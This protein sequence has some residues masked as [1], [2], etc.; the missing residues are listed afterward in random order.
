MRALWYECGQW[1]GKYYEDLD[2]F[3]TA[4]KRLLWDLSEFDLSAEEEYLVVKCIIL[5]PSYSHADLLSKFIEGALD[6]FGYE[7]LS[8]DISKGVVNLRFR[9]RVSG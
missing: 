3:S 7:P 6:I 5:N 2:R 8:E 1:Y 9:R 4:V